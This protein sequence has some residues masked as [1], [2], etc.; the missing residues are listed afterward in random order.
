MRRFLAFALLAATGFACTAKPATWTDESLAREGR[1]YRE[2]T[3]YRRA[4]L[5]HSLTHH[6][7]LY[8]QQRLAS[9]ALGTR[10]WDLLPEWNPRSRPVSAEMAAN[11]E[12]GEFPTISADAPK[13]WDGVEPATPAAWI[14]LGRR[15]FLE[16]PM[17][18][19]VFMEYGLTKP[20]LASAVGLERTSDGA[21]PGV[22]AFANVDG[23]TRLGI[24]CALCHAT[25]RDGSLVIG[26]ARRRFDYGRLRV[27]YFDET[28]APVDPELARRTATWGPG[29]ADVSEDDDENPVT[30][31]DLWGLTS[32][33]FLTQTGAIR[34][35]SPLALAIRQ[36][37]QLTDS[38][39]LMIRPPRTL[40]W[41]LVM[42]VRSLTPPA[43]RMAASSPPI[44][45]GASLFAER[46]RGCHSNEAHGGGAIPLDAI[47]TDP[48]L[49][50]GHG[51]G[52]GAYR[53]P[54]LVRVRDGAPYLHDGSIS[55][56]AELLSADRLAAS[57]TAGRLGPGA[58][59]GH[60]AGTDLPD[61]DRAALIAFLETL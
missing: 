43:E 19:D 28:H 12:R 6:E 23:N 47:G 57:Y 10:G 14:A 51:R 7:N 20:A 37:T 42:Y 60:R 56:L 11:I 31:P 61:A 27:A 58:I 15:V 46:C 26:S 3:A 2:D 40:V 5:E 54:P 33:S 16:Y 55:S 25:V 4:A 24:T 49:A 52:T 9:Y 32:Q 8:S 1:R 38:N 36:E 44:T 21:V 13:L 39:H 18:A 59:P 48:S 50:N 45:R 30:I 41:A 22:V 34:N 35:D 17:R 29:R 53:T